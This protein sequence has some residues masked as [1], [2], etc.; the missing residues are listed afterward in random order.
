MIKGMTGFG[1][2]EVAWKQ[3]KGSLEI[4]SQNHRYFDLVL[5]LPPG[6]S[7]REEK[8]RQIIGARIKRGRVIVSFKMTKHA[9]DRRVMNKEVIQDYLRQARQLKKTFDF[10]T[11][12]ALADLVKL[13]GVIE[14]EE[15]PLDLNRFWPVFEKTIKSA[16]DSCL[17]M[18]QREGKSLTV[19]LK[20][21][22]KFMLKQVKNIQHHSRGLLTQQKK[23]LSNEEFA[24]FQRANDI[25]E[26]LARLKHYIDEFSLLLRSNVS[27]GKKMDF[28]AQEMQRETNTIGSKI[29]HAAVANA[30][31]SLK[32]S[33]EKLR[34]QAQNIE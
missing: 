5:Y 26:E 18:R 27:V 14:T 19:D 7:V 3:V 15:Q 2:R 10:N 25:N 31:I 17:R 30:V 12:L 8:I 24:S 34:E 22:L 4:K 9:M 11:Q 16:L 6:F 29:Q 21:I 13:P 23:R 1:A 28:V 33:I 20:K 32:S